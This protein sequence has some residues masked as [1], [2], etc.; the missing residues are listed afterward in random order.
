MLFISHCSHPLPC[1]YTRVPFPYNN[2]PKPFFYR[3]LSKYELDEK[4]ATL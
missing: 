1:T 3:F 4:N 2:I